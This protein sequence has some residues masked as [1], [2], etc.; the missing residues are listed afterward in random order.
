MN[1]ISKK[2]F[3]SMLKSED[4]SVRY[5]AVRSL[6]SLDS[7]E[8]FEMVKIHFEGETDN[9]VKCVLG[10]GVS[11]FKSIPY[12]SK[13]ELIVKVLEKTL[14]SSAMGYLAKALENLR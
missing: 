13:K 3:G 4:G 7:L 2:A 10:I 9:H 11:D 14:P 5:E 8:A 1:E 6:C 12:E